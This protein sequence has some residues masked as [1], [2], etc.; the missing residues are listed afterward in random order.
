MGWAVF[1]PTGTRPDARLDRAAGRPPWGC[2]TG[3]LPLGPCRGEPC[4]ARS[5]LML[6]PPELDI[7]KVVIGYGLEALRFAK[8]NKA[9]LLVNG[10]YI[11]NEVERRGH[12]EEWFRIAFELGMRGLTPIP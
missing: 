3:G 8:T 11:P 2:N 9:A 4:A 10:T 1:C 5:S 6:S 12:A 7:E